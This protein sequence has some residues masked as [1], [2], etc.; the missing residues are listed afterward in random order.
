MLPKSV[1]EIEDPGQARTF[2]DD[3]M[4]DRLADRMKIMNGE[5][6]SEE[7]CAGDPKLKAG[8]AA[9]FRYLTLTG[10]AIT[11]EAGQLTHMPA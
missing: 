9:W 7:D 10:G 1:D 5:I 2:F 11:G 4:R 8:L 3:V 6:R